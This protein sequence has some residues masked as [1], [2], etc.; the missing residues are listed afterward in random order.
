MEIFV[1]KRAIIPPEFFSVQTT[2]I[3]VFPDKVLEHRR[4]HFQVPLKTDRMSLIPYNLGTTPSAG[5]EK[6][7]ILFK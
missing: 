2:Q 6:H 1:L 7:T 5:P 3:L 4:I